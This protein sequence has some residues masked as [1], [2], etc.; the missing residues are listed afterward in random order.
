MLPFPWDDVEQLIWKAST[1]LVITTWGSLTP[2]G[3]SGSLCL[4]SLIII[5][6][7]QVSLKP[8]TGLYLRSVSISQA[9]VRRHSRFTAGI[10]ICLASS[11]SL[12]TN[13]EFGNYFNGS[14]QAQEAGKVFQNI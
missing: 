7:E 14:T 5:E 3:A 6:H 2:Q 10:T 1:R 8:F 9:S 12:M 13:S 4:Q 11:K